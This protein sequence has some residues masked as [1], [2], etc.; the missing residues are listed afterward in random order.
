MSSLPKQHILR[1]F[2]WVVIL[3]LWSHISTAQILGP[4]KLKP[5]IDAT[6]QQDAPVLLKQSNQNRQKAPNQQLKY[7]DKALKAAQDKRQ[8]LKDKAVNL[9]GDIKLLR[10]SVVSAAAL[11]QTHES[12]IVALTVKLKQV[13]IKLTKK[14]TILKRRRKQMGAVLQALE[15]VA[16]YPPE[17]LFVLP[18]SPSD[19]VRTAILLRSTIPKLARRA[20]ALRDSLSDLEF[21]QNKARQHR[22]DLNEANTDLQGQRKHLRTLLGRK[23]RMRRRTISQTAEIDQKAK[24]LR[25]EARSLR[26]LMQRL[27]DIRKQREAQEKSLRLS[28]KQGRKP[29]V[30]VAK[31]PDEYTGKPIDIAKGKLPYPV[32][33]NMK[34]AFGQQGASGLTHKGVTIN[35]MY[36]AQV[37]APYEGRVAF[38]G[39][40]R[41]YGKL[42]IIEHGAGYHTLL[43]GMGRIDVIVGQWLLGGEPVGIMDKVKI[44]NKEDNP[45]L[46]IELRRGGEPI[47]PLPWLA[48]RGKPIEKSKVSG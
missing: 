45:S 43:A 44:D 33:G 30:V 42:L 2:F 11:I 35:A 34:A 32:V 5:P 20:L 12:R 10:G 26:D 4:V 47:N 27:E 1:C 31:P 6:I 14:K 48:K 16:Q 23:S 22:S 19:T 8:L 46:Y 25:K 15:R 37:I 9:D 21:N 36:E 7:I 38:T 28:E 13:N 41:G 18:I 17:A 40:F 39:P 29:S 3:F 24:E